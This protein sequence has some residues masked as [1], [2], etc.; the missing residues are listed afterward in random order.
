MWGKIIFKYPM[1]RVICLI[2]LG[3]KE[4]NLLKF[5]CEWRDGREGG[6]LINLFTL[7]ILFR[8]GRERARK[9]RNGLFASFRRFSDCMRYSI[10]L[11]KLIIWFIFIW[12]DK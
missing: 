1:S 9:W 6:E 3:G 5:E 10:V 12:L 7:F 11:N 8:V 4:L 2:L